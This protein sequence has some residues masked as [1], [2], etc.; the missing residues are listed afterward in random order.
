MFWH[1]RARVQWLLG[2]WAGSLGTY[3]GGRGGDGGGGAVHIRAS[4]TASRATWYGVGLTWGLRGGLTGVGE[5]VGA[6]RGEGGEGGGVSNGV[7]GEASSLRH[8][9]ASESHGGDGGWSPNPKSSGRSPQ[10]HSGNEGLE[11]AEEATLRGLDDVANC[12][13]QWVGN[14]R[15]GAGASPTQMYGSETQRSRPK[16]RFLASRGRLITKDC[17][18]CRR[19]STHTCLLCNTHI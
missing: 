16:T 18:M 12:S 15:V 14:E 7:W 19:G 4:S 1:C 10:P 6:R 9:S 5:V 3:L 11:G 2:G 17:P 8:F 13:P